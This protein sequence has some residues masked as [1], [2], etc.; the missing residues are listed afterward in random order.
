MVIFELAGESYAVEGVPPSWE[1]RIPAKFLPF[2]TKQRTKTEVLVRTR[3]GREKRLR[4]PEGPHDLNET[5]R[6]EYGPQSVLVASDWCEVLLD[7]ESWRVDLLVH[8]DGGPTFWGILENTLRLLTAY[9]LLRSGGLLVHSNAIVHSGRAAM[10][11]GHSGSGKTTTAEFAE[12]AG[13]KVLSDDL[14]AIRLINEKWCV[15]QLPFS[16]RTRV[17]PGSPSIFEL[18][19]LWRLQKSDRD[20]AVS[21]S[22]AHSASLLAGSSP[23]VNAD[24]Y[25]TTELLEILGKLVNAVPISELFFTR[26]ES[27]LNRLF[28]QPEAA[29]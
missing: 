6:L 11:F 10:L 22:A 9:R 5:T 1:A 27:F 20:S 28:A 4:P 21:C 7:L 12:A 16:G 13:Y 23:F 8:E 26:S 19:S 25:R 29:N 15:M 18:A 24:R 14:N 17:S 2:E 3:T